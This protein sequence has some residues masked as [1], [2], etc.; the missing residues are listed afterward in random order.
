MWLTVSVVTGFS[1][2]IF[3]GQ[4]IIGEW[5]WGFPC[6]ALLQELM[7]HC[8]NVDDLGQ[9]YCAEPLLHNTKLEVMICHMFNRKLAQD[10]YF[11]QSFFSVYHYF[12]ILND[13]HKFCY[14]WFC[15]FHIIVCGLIWLVYSYAS[16]LFIWQNWSYCKIDPMSVK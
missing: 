6:W 13:S 8:I 4:N 15:F 14:S 9:K 1:E 16:Q 5:Y 7:L 12:I 10:K 2:C 3:I 11:G